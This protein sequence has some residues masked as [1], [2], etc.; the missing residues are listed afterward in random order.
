ME[1]I[2]GH[3]EDCKG[4]SGAFCLAAFAA[5]TNKH[6]ASEIFVGAK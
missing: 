1:T 5:T 2:M 6:K 3:Y 4:K